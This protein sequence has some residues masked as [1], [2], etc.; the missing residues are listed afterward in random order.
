[1][2]DIIMHL[3]LVLIGLILHGSLFY[4]VLKICDYLDKVIT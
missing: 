1:M 4:T 2:K 3:L